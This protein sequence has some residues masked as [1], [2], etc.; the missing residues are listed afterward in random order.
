MTVTETNIV[1]EK[2][3]AQINKICLDVRDYRLGVGHIIA[4]YRLNN[5]MDFYAK[6]PDKDVKALEDDDFMDAFTEMHEVTKD[7]SCKR[8]RQKAI[9]IHVS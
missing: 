5:Q 7:P 4:A 3:V 9:L 6:N 1:S 8:F 2:I